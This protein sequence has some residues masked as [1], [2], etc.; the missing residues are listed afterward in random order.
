M[1]TADSPAK[2]FYVLLI[3]GIILLS[4]SYTAPTYADDDGGDDAQERIWYTSGGTYKSYWNM[5]NINSNGRFCLDWGEDP[6]VDGC[7]SYGGLDANNPWNTTECTDSG[8]YAT[9]AVY[10]ARWN[11]QFQQPPLCMIDVFTINTTAG[12]ALLLYESIGYSIYSNC[13]GVD[14]ITPLAS[15]LEYDILGGS[16]MDC[17]HKLTSHI[18]YDDQYT[19]NPNNAQNEEM[20]V[21]SI[22]YAIQDATVV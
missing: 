13:N 8:G 3:S 14:F 10:D 19:S 5:D 11:H 12:D 21:W 4:L 20:S 6:A 7:Q 2:P 1:N 16:A 15:S 18:G 17:T 22:V 9:N